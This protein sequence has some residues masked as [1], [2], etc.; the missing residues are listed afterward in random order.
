MLVVNLEI[1]IVA[2]KNRR[3][4]KI[5]IP[6][7]VHPWPHELRVA[8]LLAAAGH[9]VDFLATRTMRTADILL[10]GVEYEI[11]SPER[12]TSNTLEHTIKDALK[13][14]PNLIIDMSRMK[15][16][17]STK[18]LNFLLNQVRK[19]KQIKRMLLIT[20]REEIIDIKAL[21]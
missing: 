20:K 3:K 17:S 2:M 14:S 18:M 8:E 21:L 9:V 1:K 7:G 19:S 11:K 12:F 13:Q 5:I 10:D 6:S 16:V 15:R 4:G